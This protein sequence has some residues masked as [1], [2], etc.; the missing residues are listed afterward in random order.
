[1]KHPKQ[2][3]CFCKYCGV[4]EIRPRKRKIVTCFECK[5]KQ[6]KLRSIKYKAK[7]LSTGRLAN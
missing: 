5:K 3:I 7:K 2:I 1:M 6:V 4:K